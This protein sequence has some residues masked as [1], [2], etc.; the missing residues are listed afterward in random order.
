M[1]ENVLITG[2]AGFIGSHLADALIMARNRVTILDLLDPQVH[3][4]NRI[5]PSYL[6]PSVKLVA[7]D[8]HDQPLV[9]SLVAD[10]DVVF[11]LAAQ[12]GVGQSMYRIQDY[13]HTNVTGTGAVLEA[14]VTGH[15]RIRKLILASSR[16]IYGEGAGLCSSCGLIN[17]PLRSIADLRAGM[18]ETRC[19]RCD[20][21]VTPI[22]TPETK[23]PTP[24]SVYA[25]S[26]LS[27]EQTC[28]VVGQSYE[29]PVVALRFFNVFGPRQSP[30]N[31]YTG[32][33]VALM[34]RASSGNSLE[35]YEDGKQT[36]DFVHV[37]DVVRACLLAMNGTGADGQAV[38]VGSGQAVSLLEVAQIVSEEMHGLAPVVT[39]KFRIGD[40]R[41]CNAD[42][43]KIRSALG[44]ASQ[45]LLRDGIRELAKQFLDNH[46]GDR[47]DRAEREL[48]E[49]G[50]LGTT[51]Q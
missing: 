47:S 7:A 43:N 29:L 12:T 8:V 21:L 37:S 24:G 36:R 17:P 5:P 31:P 46:W 20:R 22:P 2:G 42:V 9:R 28:L 51:H 6:H 26:K 38:N 49:Y 48:L 50:L 14:A 39:G 41:H 35:V 45:I 27:Q 44:F 34:N 30:G 16:A 4:A 10:A 11:H 15:R 3:G 18:W 33:I 32:V 19:P 25:I 40:V 1:T 13:L 23:N